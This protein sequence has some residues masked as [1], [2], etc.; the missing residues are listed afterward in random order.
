MLS[1]RLQSGL[2]QL[3]VVLVCQDRENQNILGWR[4]LIDYA[5]HQKAARTLQKWFVWI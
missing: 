2:K 5:M 4:F 3:L 1:I